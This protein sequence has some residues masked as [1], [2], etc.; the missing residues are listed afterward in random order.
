MACLAAVVSVWHRP[1]TPE[2]P[3]VVLISIDTLK[4]SHLGCYGYAPARTPNI[5]ALGGRGTVF[6]NAYTPFPRTTPAIASLFT[7]LWP[8]EHGSREVKQPMALRPTLA[9]LLKQHGYHTVAMAGSR[10]EGRWPRGCSANILGSPRSSR[11]EPTRN[12]RQGSLQLAQVTQESGRG[13]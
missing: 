8:F 2:H 3:D 7:G 6:R 4:A 1:S 11:R 5:D 12:E 10:G 13:R 9:A